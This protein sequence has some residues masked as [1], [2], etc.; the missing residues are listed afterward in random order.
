[1]SYLMH[2][3]SLLGVLKETSYLRLRL[4]HSAQGL[5]FLDKNF[6]FG[7]MS[8]IL[9]RSYSEVKMLDLED[10]ISLLIT[11]S[12]HC[13]FYILMSLKMTDHD[14]SVFGGQVKT[15]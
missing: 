10:L 3:T 12:K 7:L 5:I 14:K 6:G 1:M 15:H 4:M 8:K 2:S 13:Y 11:F 9:L